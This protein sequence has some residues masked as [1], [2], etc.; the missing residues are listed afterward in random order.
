L[1][2]KNYVWWV[3]YAEKLIKK[4]EHVWLKIY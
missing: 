2:K 4:N 3:F 1:V